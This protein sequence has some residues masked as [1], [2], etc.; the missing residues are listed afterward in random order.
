MGEVEGREDEDGV[1]EK[2]GEEM[3]CMIHEAEGKRMRKGKEKGRNE[4]EGE[5]IERGGGEET[6]LS[7]ENTRTREK[8]IDM[9]DSKGK[10]MSIWDNS[11]GEM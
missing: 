8:V 5:Q 6:S 9:R 4:L 10:E 1:N 3:D 11:E 7:S 2:V